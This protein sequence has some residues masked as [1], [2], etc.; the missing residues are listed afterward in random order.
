MGTRVGDIDA[1]A[2]V[3]LGEVLKCSLRIWKSSSTPEV[4][5]GISGKVMISEIC[6][7]GVSGDT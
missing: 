7:P 6:S 4:D 1:G 2:V 3:R 5:L